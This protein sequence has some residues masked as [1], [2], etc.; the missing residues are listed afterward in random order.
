MTTVE[1]WAVNHFWPVPRYPVK[2]LPA[3][4]KVEAQMSSR[5]P[6]CR[7]EDSS[8][9]ARSAMRSRCG[10]GEMLVMPFTFY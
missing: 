1:Y 7:E 2:P 4:D 9:L 3:Q 10:W 5:P 6:S 8:N